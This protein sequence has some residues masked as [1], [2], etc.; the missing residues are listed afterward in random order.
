MARCTCP[1]EQPCTC[2]WDAFS[3]GFQVSGLG[4]AASPATMTIADSGWQTFASTPGLTLLNGYTAYAGTTYDIPAYRTVFAFPF[5]AVMVFFRGR[6]E[7]VGAFV[8][9]QQILSGLPAGIIPARYHQFCVAV[10]GLASGDNSMIEL[11]SD[12][13]MFNIPNRGST[14]LQLD[15]LHYASV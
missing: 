13:T 12:G 7:K 2:A 1:E 5:G 9:G 6:L 11:R 4:T 3:N 10:G 14:W 8:A 15:G